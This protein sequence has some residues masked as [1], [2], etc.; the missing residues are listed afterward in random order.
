MRRAFAPSRLCALVAGV[1][2]VAAIAVRGQ[3]IAGTSSPTMHA[4]RIVACDAHVQS[5][6]R[7]VCANGLSN[8]DFRALSPGVSWWYNWGGDFDKYPI[9]RGVP[10][11]Y[12]PMAWGDAPGSLESLKRYLA[13]GNRPHYVFG[14]NEP[15]LRGQ[16]FIPPRE[17]AALFARIRSV[18]DAYRI[19]LI[20]PQMAI[21]SRT[22]DS[23]SA[24]D[25]IEKKNLVY[26]FM[27]P[28]LK[29]FRFYL[30]QDH[31][32]DSNVAG[33]A[34]HIYDNIWAL[35]ALVE[36]AH[37]ETGL[38]VWVTEYA[39]R[40]G[41]EKAQREFLV[42][43]TD[44]LERT[45]YVAGYAWFKERIS[46]PNWAA[47]LFEA[48]PGQLSM[49]GKSYVALPV[50]DADV[51]YRLP[52]RLPAVN[53]VTLSDADIYPDPDNNDSSYMSAKKTGATIDYNVQ[54]DHPGAYAIQISVKGK[55]GTID[56]VKGNTTLATFHHDDADS[57]STVS[58]SAE[59]NRGPQ[60]LSLRFDDPDQNIQWLDFARR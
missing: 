33:I 60:M 32:S 36:L 38:P 40:T 50:H 12:R 2:L 3:D 1:L 59:L 44:F 35:K 15:N 54:V 42:Q 43:A 18:T 24:F 28:Y 8:A 46:D 26:S 13:A 7:G 49:L 48:E 31:P 5:R 51:Y 58:G 20:A 45:P 30:K 56:L 23:I 17:C 9:P 16:A 57:W 14:I 11:E 34:I 39:S 55:A 29:A 37:K 41:D 10:M 52:G 53:Y 19:P 4:I 47:G 27:V 6:K 21:G 25:P 22:E